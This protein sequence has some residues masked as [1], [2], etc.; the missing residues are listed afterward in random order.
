[1]SLESLSEDSIYDIPEFELGDE[2][3]TWA[4]S[5][6]EMQD[7]LLRD[8]TDAYQEEDEYADSQ[9]GFSSPPARKPLMLALFIVFGIAAVAALAIF[10]FKLFEGPD[11]PPLEAQEQTQVEMVVDNPEEMNG[12]AEVETATASQTGD[13]GAVSARD[14]PK[15]TEESGVSPSTPD[16]STDGVWYWIRRG[17]TLWDISWNFYRTPWLYG[18]I[19]EDNSIKNPDLIFAGAKI[20]V[21]SGD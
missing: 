13:S 10:L 16:E 12:A 14:G 20:F 7:E 18:R 6:N 2:L 4:E 11:V 8:T 15:V 5:E 1:M 21:S 9:L 3:D 17:D 19:A